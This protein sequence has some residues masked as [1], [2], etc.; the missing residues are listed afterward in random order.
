MKQKLNIEVDNG[1]KTKPTNKKVISPITIAI[2]V[3]VVVI[4]ALIVI[5]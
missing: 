5:L 4:I 1:G 2:I 3:A